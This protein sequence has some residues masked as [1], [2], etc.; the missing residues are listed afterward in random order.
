MRGSLAVRAARLGAAVVDPKD[1]GGSLTGWG[2]SAAP[3]TIVVIDDEL[4]NVLNVI[5][6]AAF[7][8]SG[9]FEYLPALSRGTATPQPMPRLEF[10]T[11]DLAI[12]AEKN[13]E[14]EIGEE[15]SRLQGETLWFRMIAGG[16]APRFL[17]LRPRPNLSAILDVPNERALPE[18]VN[19]FVAKTTIEILTLRPT[20]SYGLEA[21]S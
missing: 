6:H 1:T 14:A 18:S 17:R 4:D 16:P 10:T 2:R 12:G 7:V 8:G 20:M 9:L 5:R 11:V 13:F 3:K 19:N 15:Q 21:K